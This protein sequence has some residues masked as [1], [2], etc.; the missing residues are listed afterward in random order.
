MPLHTGGTTVLRSSGKLFTCMHLLCCCKHCRSV[1][2]QR[3]LTR[4]PHGVCVPSYTVYTCDTHLLHRRCSPSGSQL[5]MIRTA[6][7]ACCPSLLPLP[8][9]HIDLRNTHGSIILPQTHGIIP[10]SVLLSSMQQVY[11]RCPWQKKSF[12]P[13]A[14]ASSRA[15]D[16]LPGPGV[17][18]SWYTG[19]C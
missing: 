10:A 13:A 17:V 14:Y 8:C 4:R 5:V 12:S 9:R 19:S 16:A 15:D 6:C 1:K 18:Q 2:Q 11:Q 7:C 3:V